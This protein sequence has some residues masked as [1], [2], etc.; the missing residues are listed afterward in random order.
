MVWKESL[1]IAAIVA[2]GFALVPSASAHGDDECEAP[3]AGGLCAV[4][5]QFFI[6]C[7]PGGVPFAPCG[8][9]ILMGNPRCDPPS[10][11]P[12]GNGHDNGREPGE[13][14]CNGKGNHCGGD[15]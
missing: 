13:G 5:C 12:N 11:H 10:T 3:E 9:P 8:T 1:M 6:D 15:P 4:P 7:W 2:A 14:N